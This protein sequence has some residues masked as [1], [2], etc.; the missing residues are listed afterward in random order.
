MQTIVYNV[1]PGRYSSREQVIDCLN[2]INGITAE[3]KSTGYAKGEILI[4]VEGEF[5]MSDAVA[6]GAFIGQ[7]E[8]MHLV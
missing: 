6:L 3:F 7:A 4:T 8:T 1:S 2:N 5:T